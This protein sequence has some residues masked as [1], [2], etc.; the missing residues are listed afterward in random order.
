[1]GEVFPF[2]LPVALLLLPEE[3]VL[4]VLVLV[5]F[6]LVEFEL[7]GPELVE[8]ELVAFVL[9]LFKRLPIY[10]ASVMLVEESADGLFPPGLVVSRL[11]LFIT[12]HMISATKQGCFKIM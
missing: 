10:S 12:R 5:E 8:F 4:C 2:P 7:V 9:V 6:E 1:M 11:L 3:L